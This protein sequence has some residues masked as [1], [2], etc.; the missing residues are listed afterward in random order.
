[1]NRLISAFD[2]KYEERLASGA[3][4]DFG[5]VFAE[6][7]VQERLTVLSEFLRPHRE[8]YAIRDLL[9]TR[10]SAQYPRYVEITTQEATSRTVTADLE[11]IVLDSAG[12]AKVF[13]EVVG[14]FHGKP[15][16]ERVLA[17]FSHMGMIAKLIDDIVD[18]WDDI[19]HGRLNILHGLLREN[20]AEHERVMACA[21]TRRAA[22]L[23][24]WRATCPTS[25]ER[26]CDLLREH[27]RCV[28]S[29]PLRLACD[30]MLVPVALRRPVLHTAPVGLRI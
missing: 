4:L 3:S 25:F 10:T 2:D 7:E 1:M 8:R 12:F 26:H 16:R 30:L 29:P 27:R 14:A 17:Q 15:P 19:A 18:F 21:A 6:L 9:L 20:A 11:S 24:W 28:T 13:A 5:A 22:G 23:R